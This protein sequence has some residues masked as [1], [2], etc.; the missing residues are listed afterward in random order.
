MSTKHA[1]E[2]AARALIPPVSSGNLQ[3]D[4]R[5]AARRCV[6]A[7][8]SAIA[9]DDASVEAAA[10]SMAIDQDGDGAWPHDWDAA[11]QNQYRNLAHAAVAALLSCAKEQQR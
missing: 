11:D 2:A 6:I 7:Y 5:S 1:I 8:L 9:E 3:M 10:K 4:L